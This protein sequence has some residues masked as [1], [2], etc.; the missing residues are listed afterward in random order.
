MVL[1]IF[2]QNL[3]GTIK[4]ARFSELVRTRQH[5][6]SCLGL[7]QGNKGDEHKAKKARPHPDRRIAN[8]MVPA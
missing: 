6:G 2:L 4:V 8:F 1:K 3:T 5:L 7:S